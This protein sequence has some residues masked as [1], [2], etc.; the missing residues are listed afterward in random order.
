[1][2]LPSGLP[3]SFV[4]KNQLYVFGYQLYICF[5]L[6]AL[7]VVF[8]ICDILSHGHRYV[9]PSSSYPWLLGI[10][11]WLLAHDGSRLQCQCLYYATADYL[12]G[13]TLRGCSCVLGG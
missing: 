13:R 8:T 7:A 10:N 3:I 11:A 12:L 6:A 1:M 2:L 4:T 9:V 5:V